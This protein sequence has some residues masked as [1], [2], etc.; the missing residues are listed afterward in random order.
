MRLGELDAAR[1]DLQNAL[2]NIEARELSGL[3]PL[4]HGALG[5]LS[6][7]AGRVSEARSHLSAAVT[8]WTDPLP[9]PASI[10]AQCYRGL[11]DALAGRAG[12][13]TVL[14]AAV[15]QAKR[16]GRLALEALCRVQLAQVN[17]QEKRFAQAVA[18]LKEI[19]EDTAERTIG[20]ELRARTEYWTGVA[21]AGLGRVDGVAHSNEARE[22][23]REL[24]SGL[25]AEFRELFARRSD[26]ATILMYPVRSHP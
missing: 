5:E 21:N 2:T 1:V 23:L 24:Q 10:Q 14:E 12:T 4:I 9:N 16:S 25:P 3:V 20:P 6:Y 13:H 15:D 22:Q 19:P 7:E 18:A 17:I 11:R 26:I 8:S